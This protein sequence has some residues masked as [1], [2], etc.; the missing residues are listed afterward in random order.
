LDGDVSEE[1]LNLFEFAA[2][3]MGSK[4]RV[5]GIL[6]GREV[7]RFSVIGNSISV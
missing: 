1:K 3:W 6:G 5:A 4:V 2:R 7:D